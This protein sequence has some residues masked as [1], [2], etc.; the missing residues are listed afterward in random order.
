MTTSTGRNLVSTRNQY[1]PFSRQNHIQNNN[2]KFEDILAAIR[3]LM[4]SQMTAQTSLT[5]FDLLDEDPDEVPEKGGVA[6]RRSE[7][8]RAKEAMPNS[9]NRKQNAHMQMPCHILHRT[10]YHRKVDCKH[11]PGNL[12]RYF[13][14]GN[15][16]GGVCRAYTNLSSIREKKFLDSNRFFYILN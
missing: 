6:H 4:M 1:F 10:T 16:P 9:H 14:H 12:H 3:A 2:K 13:I 7:N 15:N 5:R 8:R 11:R